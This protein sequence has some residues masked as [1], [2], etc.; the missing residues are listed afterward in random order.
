LFADEILRFGIIKQGPVGDDLAKQGLLLPGFKSQ[1]DIEKETQKNLASAWKLLESEISSKSLFASAVRLARSDKHDAALVAFLAAVE[2]RPERRRVVAGLGGKADGTVTLGV[3]SHV[4]PESLSA[5]APDSRLMR[6]GFI[7]VKSEG[8]WATR[9][10]H[11]A[12]SLVWSLIGSQDRDPELPIDIEHISG[13]SSSGDA[14]VILVAGPDRSARRR[15]ALVRLGATRA[16]AIKGT[17]ESINWNVCVKQEELFN[18]LSPEFKITE[19]GIEVIIRSLKVQNT[20]T[21]EIKIALSKEEILPYLV[22]STHF[23]HW[24]KK[25]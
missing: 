20:K 15:R 14:Q 23:Y 13:V 6:S 9:E 16:I 5:A 22:P 17:D 24:F 2:V 1:D 8:S 25:R 21:N 10:I 12:P 4:L 18:F 19:T 3:I 11:L 7:Q